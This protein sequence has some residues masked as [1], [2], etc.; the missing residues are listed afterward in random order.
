[1]KK[2]TVKLCLPVLVVVSTTAMAQGEGVPFG[3]MTAY[4]SVGLTFGFDDN[5]LLTSSNEVDSMVTRLSPGVRLEHQAGSTSVSVSY[6]IDAGWYADS[7]TDNYIDHDL[8]ANLV[9]QIN[10]RTKFDLSAQYKKDHDRRGSGSRQGD[11]AF[12][13]LDPDEYSDIGVDG[14]ITFGGIGSKGSVEL[15]GGVLNRE[16]DNNRSYTKDFDRDTNFFGGTFFWQIQPKTSLL[17]EVKNT[18]IDY[19][20]NNGRDSDET[21]YQVGAKWDATA[22]TSGTFKIGRLEKDFDDPSASDFSGTSWEL[23]MAFKPKSYSTINLATARETNESTGFGNFI[24]SRDIRLG[25]THDW[26][27]RLSTSLDAAQ[28]NDEH[29]GDIRD[30]DTSDFGVSANYEFR[31]WLTVGAGYHHSSRDSNVNE[32]DYTQNLFMLTLEGSL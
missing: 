24:L 32:Y 6:E 7:S 14:A 20:E 29:R 25:W 30:D 11:L 23:G 18:Q 19:V 1:M 31:R 15:A 2:W 27:S 26:S 22:K 10:D 12:L 9:Q 13:D 17:V 4:P 16:Y 3:A 8:R 21:R 28:I 5:V